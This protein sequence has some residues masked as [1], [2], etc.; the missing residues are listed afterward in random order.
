MMGRSLTI[1]AMML[2]YGCGKAKVWRARLS[3]DPPPVDCDALARVTPE[4]RRT[5]FLKKSSD[6][7]GNVLRLLF[8]PFL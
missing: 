6:G 3:R 5:F 7:V 4:E 1:L 8:P 2:L